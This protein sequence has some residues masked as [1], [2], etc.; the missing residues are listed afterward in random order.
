MNVL[1]PCQHHPLAL[2]KVRVHGSRS[3]IDRIT[4]QI[5]RDDNEVLQRFL[6]SVA[7]QRALAENTR[8]SLISHC[9]TF[10]VRI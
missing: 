3:F 10:Q 6:Q 1:P 8:Q 5:L 2:V 4:C 9:F 7:W